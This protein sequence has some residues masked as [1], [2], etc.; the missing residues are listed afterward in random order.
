MPSAGFPLFARSLFCDMDTFNEKCAKSKSDFKFANPM[1][2]SILSDMYG[3][4][5]KSIGR[6][7]TAQHKTT[8]KAAYEDIKILKDITDRYRN[9]QTIKGRDKCYKNPVSSLK[10][11]ILNPKQLG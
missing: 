8:V 5:T 7:T 6:H 9:G 11:F 3:E 4:L 1:N 10:V 2:E